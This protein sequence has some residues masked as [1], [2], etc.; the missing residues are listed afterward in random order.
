[1]CSLRHNS[2]RETSAP[3]ARKGGLLRTSTAVIGPLAGLLSVRNGCLVRTSHT[4]AVPSALPARRIQPTSE[5]CLDACRCG[6]AAH[7]MIRLPCELN[8]AVLDCNLGLGGRML[9]YREYKS[10]CVPETR[11]VPSLENAR[12]VTVAVCPSSSAMPL[13]TALPAC[14]RRQLE[15]VRQTLS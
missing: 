8:A 12:Q 15:Q 10:P 6:L 2:A 3:G 7:D 5:T 11:R 1:M 9:K 14:L 13:A 4:R